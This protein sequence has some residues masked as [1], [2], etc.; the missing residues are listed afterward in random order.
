MR[1]GFPAWRAMSREHELPAAAFI[2][3]IATPYSRRFR[4]FAR[5][6][7]GGARKD[8]PY[9]A[10]HD[11][12]IRATGGDGAPDIG[13]EHYALPRRARLRY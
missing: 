9:A 4:H 7:S 8:T 3:A 12:R 13:I 11:A 10:R 5:A 1:R 2:F 6:R